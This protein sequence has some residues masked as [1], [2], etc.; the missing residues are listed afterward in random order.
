MKNIRMSG[1][2]VVLEAR[3]ASECVDKICDAIRALTMEI[4][5][6]RLVPGST[7]IFVKQASGPDYR[8]E[9]QFK[10]GEYVTVGIKCIEEVKE[11]GDE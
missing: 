9:V 3:D 8:H 1:D 7:E 2:F 11:D 10:K 4:D 6:E 5:P